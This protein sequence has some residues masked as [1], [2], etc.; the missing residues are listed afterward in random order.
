MVGRVAVGLL[1]CPPRDLNPDVQY[2]L[3]EHQT[4]I[5]SSQRSRPRKQRS[6]F[7]EEQFGYV[8]LHEVRAFAVGSDYL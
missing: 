8:M 7:S 3:E 5:D 1:P 4:A 6:R 2:R